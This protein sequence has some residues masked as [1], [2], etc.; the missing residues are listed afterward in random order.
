MA[1]NKA[2]RIYNVN[3]SGQSITSQTVTPNTPN[4]GDSTVTDNNGVSFVIP[5]PIMAQM[6]QDVDGDTIINIS[7]GTATNGGDQILFQVDGTNVGQVEILASGTTKWTL[8]GILDPIVYAGSPQTTVQRDAL[9]ALAGYMLYNSDT[10]Q[11]EYYNGTV[12]QAISNSVLGI[13]GVLAQNEVLT[14][15]RSITAQNNVTLTIA[16]QNVAGDTNST[17]IMGAGEI[18]LQAVDNGNSFSRIKTD[19]NK[20]TLE[21]G[22][23]T[24]INIPTI[25]DKTTQTTKNLVRDEATGDLYVE[26]SPTLS[27]NQLW[28]AQGVLND[29]SPVNS[30]NVID[31]TS[32]VSGGILTASENNI[33]GIRTSVDT[34]SPQENGI[35]KVTLSIYK[36]SNAIIGSNNQV[37]GGTV[38]AG[39]ELN[40]TVL[41]GSFDDSSG[42]PEGSIVSFDLNLT[43]SDLIRF[44]FNHNADIN[45]DFY[46]T[47]SIVRLDQQNV[48]NTT[49]VEFIDWTFFNPALRANTTDPTLGNHSLIGKY[50][51]VGNTL[52]VKIELNQ[53]S[54]G[55]AGSGLYYFEIPAGYTPDSLFAGSVVDE[56]D[57]HLINSVAGYGSVSDGTSS[58]RLI[59]IIDVSGRIYM[60]GDDD[61][62]AVQMIDDSYYDVGAATMR[63]SV[64]VEIPLV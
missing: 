17:L 49:D 58:G 33:S 26:S 44:G 8:D 3:G 28:Q 7:E 4:I 52:T 24:E 9:T 32:T 39:I 53:T 41:S 40:G 57:L 37:G 5:A 2:P 55:I 16:T 43:T 21:T 10:N 29:F 51:K 47:A 31:W 12:W 56:N 27:N 48:I 61:G 38:Y 18:T 30:F 59:P 62:A 64:T 19:R 25:A 36:P 23:G 1:N 35:Y 13:D 14:V 54:A 20:L 45:E 63:Y 22:I 15:N 42:T 46:I 60:Y 11:Y 34:F 50:K 6:I